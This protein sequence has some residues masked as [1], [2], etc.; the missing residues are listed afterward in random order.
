MKKKRSGHFCRICKARKPNQA[1]SG[2]GH[3]RHICRECSKRPREEIEEIEHSDEIFGF[4]KQSHI[5]DKNIKRLRTLADSP[6]KNVAYHARI[7]IEVAEHRPFKRRRLKFLAREKP[8]LLQKLRE[9]GLIFAH[10]WQWAKE[11]R[12]IFPK[13]S[14]FHLLRLRGKRRK[15]WSH[16]AQLR[17]GLTVVATAG[18]RLLASMRKLSLRS[19]SALRPRPGTVS[20]HGQDG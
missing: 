18:R 6:Y 16:Y 8:E 15:W 2:S 19:H 3:S 13:L 9:T 5:S 4:L 12:D 17:P 20:A 7:V 1:F 10:H 14:D 11:H